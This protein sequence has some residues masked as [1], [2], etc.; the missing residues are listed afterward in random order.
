MIVLDYNKYQVINIKDQQAH[1][2]LVEQLQWA[3]WSCT[4]AK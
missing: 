2:N 4:L 1:T 3:S